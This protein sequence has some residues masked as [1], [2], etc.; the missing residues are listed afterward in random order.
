M[1]VI[2][3]VNQKGG[4]GKT[5]TAVTLAHGLAIRGYR[6]LLIDLDQQGNMAQCL[7][8]EAGNELYRLLMPGSTA[9]IHELAYSA[10][11]N[12]DVIRSD[13]TTAH[14]KIMVAGMDMREY[15]LD[16]ALKTA[17]PYDVILM[18]SAPSVDVLMNAA[19]IA[20]DYLIVPTRLEQLSVIGVRDVLDSL[21]R[22][23]TYTT[24]K[25]GGVLPTMMNRT[26]NETILQLTVLAETFGRSVWPPI[27]SDTNCTEAPRLGKTM[28]EYAPKT[29]AIVGFPDKRNAMIGGYGQALDQLENTLIERRKKQNGK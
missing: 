8:L 19:I 11:P 26:T 5:T 27:P 9:T 25:L 1:T 29:R 16:K 21:K 24:C 7:G 22:L 6:T 17:H 12:L 13:K 23:E 3:I 28:W 14:L 4:V 18:D 15:V 20:G 2:T 10:R